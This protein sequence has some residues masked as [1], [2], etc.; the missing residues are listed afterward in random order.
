MFPIPKHLKIFN[1]IGRR[2]IFFN[3][4]MMTMASVF[5]VKIQNIIMVESF[6]KQKDAD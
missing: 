2:N 6:M 4:Q 5:K 1:K 3:Q